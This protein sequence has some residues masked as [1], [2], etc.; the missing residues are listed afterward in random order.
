M[1][2][3]GQYLTHRFKFGLKY[4]RASENAMLV[5]NIVKIYVNELFLIE[6]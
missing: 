4:H 2:K 3:T 6:F 5:E 1:D